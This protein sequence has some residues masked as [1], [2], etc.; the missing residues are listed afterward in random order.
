MRERARPT[1]LVSRCAGIALLMAAIPLQAQRAEK[2]TNARVVVLSPNNKAQEQPVPTCILTPETKVDPDRRRTKEFL[3]PIVATL[4][5]GVAG[6]LVDSGVKA[7]G[8][9]LDQAS[10]EKGFLAEGEGRFLSGRIILDQKRI[11]PPADAAA[12]FTPFIIENAMYAPQ[13]HC[14]ILYLPSDDADAPPIAAIFAEPGQD[15][16]DAFAL[17]GS[18]PDDQ[19][20]TLA[21]LRAI[22]L[23]KAP[24]LYVE[25]VLFQ[26]QHGSVIRPYYVWY[27][28]KFKGAPSAAKPTELHVVLATPGFDA[29]N[30][31]IGSGYAGARLK[32]PKMKPGDALGPDDLKAYESVWLPSRPEAGTLQTALDVRKAA[33]A[34]IREKRTALEQAERALRDAQASTAKTKA[35]LVRAAQDA[36]LDAQRSLAVVT[37]AAEPLRVDASGKPVGATNVQMRFVVVRDANKFGQA[38]AKAISDQ[39]AA[40]GTALK[41]ELL[42]KP[43]YSSQDAALLAAKLEVEAKQEAYDKAVTDGADTIVINAARRA[44]ILAK[45]AA[46]TAA[47]AANA[48]NPYPEILAY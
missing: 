19:R 46:V 45:S 21:R 16:N 43:N 35:D 47:E 3:G 39:A 8:N 25:A 13:D 27:R 38:I 4:V 1:L 10:K 44:L 7:V 37:A 5:A 32:L 18:D 28:E 12:R 42:P 2:T 24:R 34:A 41:D 36:L 30:P 26:T 20:D 6:S 40:T 31:G 33:L 9:A 48:P 15:R 22:G 17:N 14:L 29:A 11:D 23:E